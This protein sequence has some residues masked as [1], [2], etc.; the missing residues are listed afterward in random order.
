MTKRLEIGLLLMGILFATMSTPRRLKAQACEDD[1]A[2]VESYRKDL[3]DLV[4]TT[5]KESL[6]QFEKTF[7]QRTCLTKLGLSLSLVKELESCLEKAGQDPAAKEQADSNKAKHEKYAKLQGKI[8][9][10]QKDLKAAQEPK[11]AK[12][13]I[14]K[15]DFS[16]N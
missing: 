11:D 6:E 1:E 8:E 15:F 7:H 14:G 13:L 3:S 10:D 12:S 2:M 16:D 9:K 5:R 4:D